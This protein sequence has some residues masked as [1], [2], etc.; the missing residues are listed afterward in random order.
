MSKT[1]YIRARIDPAL[2]HAAEKL[3][4]Q[5][6]LKTTEAITLFYKQVI[7]K[8]G[9]PFA[10]KVPNKVTKKALN[11]AKHSK[12]TKSFKTIDALFDELD[13]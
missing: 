7:A 8:K 11:I 1:D 2:K 5:L 6:G 4:K 9:L 12:N 3:F 10:V 13:T